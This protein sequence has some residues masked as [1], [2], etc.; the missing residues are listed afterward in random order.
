MR[1]RIGPY[2]YSLLWLVIAING[3]CNVSPGRPAVYDDAQGAPE[4]QD[5][6]LDMDASDQQGAEL[7]V[8]DSGP[9][10][11]LD[12]GSAPAFA[13][14]G[15]WSVFDQSSLLYAREV[16]FSLNLIVGAFPYVYTGTISVDGDFELQGNSL[17]RSGCQTARL[18]G[19]FN[20]ISSFYTLRHTSCNGQ[21]QAFTS[22]LR[23]SFQSSFAASRSGIYRLSGN[24]VADLQG[25]YTGRTGPYELIY[26]VSLDP[27]TGNL[28]IFTAKDIIEQPM[29][30]LGRYSGTDDTFSLQHTPFVGSMNALTSLTGRFEQFGANDPLRLVGQRDVIDPDTLCSFTM[31]LEGTKISGP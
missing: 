14:T 17:I 12:A 23:G 7:G 16:D 18:T 21:G 10:P 25:C 31:T 26:G 9:R 15:I 5:A 11:V 1:V 8:S 3:A 24:I 6:G 27:N 4:P 19:N 29:V 20:R 13:F 28:A 22:D 30:Y 2:F